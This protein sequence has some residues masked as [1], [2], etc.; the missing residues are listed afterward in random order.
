MFAQ[1][2]I[3]PKKRSGLVGYEYLRTKHGGHAG[4]WHSYLSERYRDALALQEAISLD[5][6]Q[7]H[8]SECVDK[9]LERLLRSDIEKDRK[10]GARKLRERKYRNDCK[11]A[12]DGA[13]SS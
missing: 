13:S 1:H 3:H 12:L 11:R 10:Q 7:S 9:E 8:V 6:A 5:T 2:L 4:N